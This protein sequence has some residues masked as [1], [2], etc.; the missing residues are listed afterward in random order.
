MKL[1]KLIKASYI[2]TFILVSSG[3]SLIFDDRI[4]DYLKEKESKPLKISSDKDIRPIVDFYP[5]PKESKDSTEKLYEVP[6][7][8]QVFSSGTSNEVRLH[9]L[10]EIRWIYVETLPSSVWPIMKDFWGA[11]QFGMMEEDPNAGIIQ[12]KPLL[13][14]NLQTKLIMKIE[15][16]IRQASSEVF[17]SHVFKSK[18]EEWIRLTGEDNLEEK[19]LLSALD[20]LSESSSSGGTSLVALN[21]NIGQKAILKQNQNLSN[22]IELNLEFPRAWA[23]VDRAL[24]EA[25]ITVTDLD[26][27]KGIFY[28]DFTRAE[29]K[30]FVRGLF[31]KDVSSRGTFKIVIKKIQE[32]KCI[33]TV[34]G[35]N[36]DSRVFERDL[37]SEIN[38]SL[39]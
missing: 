24:K 6:M 18:N 15:H 1:L 26:R 30:G 23:A 33:V 36:E 35:D 34:G 5:L 29:E 7:P 4:D 16:G 17:V 31:S 37:L 27:D 2:L 19:V 3:C 21:L 25:M 39:S 13:V 11:N 14:G 12:S 8:Q 38:Q 9:R 28:V 22:F 10:G 32:N 20:F